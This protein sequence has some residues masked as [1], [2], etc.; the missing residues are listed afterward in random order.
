LFNQIYN[1]ESSSSQIG[2]GDVMVLE[3]VKQRYK[4]QTG[5][6]FKC[7]HWWEVVR[8]QSKWR[9]RSADSSTTDP[10][11]SLTEVAT[12]EE[13]THSIGRDRTKAVA[14][15]EKENEGSSSQSESSFVM[16]VIMSTLK[17]VLYEINSKM[18]V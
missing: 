1:Q 13:V 3:I 6:K 15:N 10:F 18:I 14:R 16:D 8:H 2:A 9:V 5:S 4:N 17:F 7:L 11:L 12:D